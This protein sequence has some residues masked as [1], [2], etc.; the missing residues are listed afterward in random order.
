MVLKTIKNPRSKIAGSSLGQVFQSCPCTVN[1]KKYNI[2][3]LNKIFQGSVVTWPLVNDNEGALYFEFKISNIPRITR[4]LY[5]TFF[6]SSYIIFQYCRGWFVCYKK[7]CKN[8]LSIQIMSS[9]VNVWSWHCPL[10][11]HFVISVCSQSLI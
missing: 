8:R 9:L 4:S 2:F 5:V 1:K 10:F 11:R 7:Y 6:P 3:R